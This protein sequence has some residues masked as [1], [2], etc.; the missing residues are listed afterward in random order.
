MKKNRLPIP[1]LVRRGLF[2][3][4]SEIQLITINMD[5]G[6]TVL[7]G[8][9]KIPFHGWFIIFP[10]LTPFLSDLLRAVTGTISPLT[11]SLIGH[12]L[13]LG[14]TSLLSRPGR[15][16]QSLLDTLS[17]SLLPSAVF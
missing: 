13:I 8:H 1:D 15:K 3:G 16:K 5:L 10:G 9:R 7:L 2:G 4:S 12:Y 14:A 6:G 17:S 11:R